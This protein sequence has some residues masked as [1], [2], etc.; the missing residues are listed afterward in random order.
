MQVFFSNSRWIVS[1]IKN[2]TQIR[3]V[4]KDGRGTAT[5]YLV[6]K[7]L[8]YGDQDTF[9]RSPRIAYTNG[10]IVP[11]Y[12]KGHVTMAFSRGARWR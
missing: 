1:W 6:G 12:V 4:S 8:D 3:I 10:S 5:A 11:S 7:T 2:K 9:R